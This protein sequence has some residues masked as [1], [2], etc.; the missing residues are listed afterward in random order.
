MVEIGRARLAR[1]GER[2]TVVTH[3]AAVPEVDSALAEL[4]L[5]ADLLDLRTLQPLDADAVLTSVRK[6]GRVL[7]VEPD[8]GAHRI[9]AALVS[10]IWEQA[11]EHLDAPPRRVREPDL[12]TL[13]EV[14]GELLGY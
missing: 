1:E 6:T 14:S 8:G 4:E 7:F 11:F 10:E 2:L 13:R 3:G 9:T 5:D 12:E